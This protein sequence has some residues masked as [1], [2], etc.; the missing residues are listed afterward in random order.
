[1]KWSQLQLFFKLIQRQDIQ[2]RKW[3]LFKDIEMIVFC[4]YII[5]TSS[6]GT[7]HKLIIILINITKQMEMIIRFTV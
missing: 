2:C 6:N 4:N 3:Y 1:M 7:I 5:S